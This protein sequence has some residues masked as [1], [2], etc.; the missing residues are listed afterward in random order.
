MISKNRKYFTLFGILAATVDNKINSLYSLI[1]ELISL[2]IPK[3]N[4]ILH[5]SVLK[6]IKQVKTTIKN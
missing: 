5:S 4:N 6:P 2:E 3:I 1:H